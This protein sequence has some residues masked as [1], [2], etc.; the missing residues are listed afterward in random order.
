[1]DR[2]LGQMLDHFESLGVAE[3]TLILFLGDN[4]SDAPLGHQHQVA[5]AAPLRGKKGAHYEGGMRVPFIAAWAKPNASNDLQRKWNIAANTIQPQVASVVDLFPTV[6]DA[7][8]VAAPE[9]HPIDGSSLRSLMQGKPDPRRKEQ[10]LMH[11][12]H[13]P[14]RSNYFSTWRDGDWK[15]IYH[16]LPDQPTTGGFIQTDAGH[17]ELFNLADDPFESTNLASTKPAELKRM[18]AGLIAQLEDHDAVYAID[19]QGNP[20]PPEMP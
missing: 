14:H 18:M 17:Y 2:S 3:E 9:E 16:A 10:F 15:V 6:L 12:P 8:G 13:G 1:M 4:G 5:C 11:Y 19:D 20:L 7:T